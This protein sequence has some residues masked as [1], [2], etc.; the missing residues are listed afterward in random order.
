MKSKNI[1]EFFL[2]TLTDLK[3]SEE[4]PFDVYVYFPSN[5]HLMK[6]WHSGHTPNEERLQSY[7]S[8]GLYSVWV[9]KNDRDTF[10]AYKLRPKTP[11]G[12]LLQTISMEQTIKPEQKRELFAETAQAML[13][14]ALDATTKEEQKQIESV[15]QLAIQDLLRTMQNKVV[16]VIAEIWNIPNIDEELRHSANVAAYAVLLSLAAGKNEPETISTVALA[17][18]L[19]DVGLSQIPMKIVNK[20]WKG[21]SHNVKEQY[22]KHVEEGCMILR[23]YGT[24][25]P[26][27]VIN[28]IK[29]HHYR[30]HGVVENDHK[31]SRA[32]DLQISQTLTIAELITAVSS[33][34]W[35][36]N[37]RNLKETLKSL[38]TIFAGNEASEQFDPEIFT[39]LLN[40]IKESNKAE[41]DRTISEAIQFVRVEASK[42]IV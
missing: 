33:G 34:Q 4:I 35:D 40:W 21:M 11:V 39:A 15:L 26:D 18:L 13:V 24:D 41:Q 37:T 25:I 10:A 36:G 28:A 19:H 1:E 30:L 32:E 12:R 6:L 14:Q 17:G 31:N 2:V 42:V 23:K 27:Q 8:R 20:P 3:P 9:H 29:H 5:A 7:R 22:I 38:E 16:S